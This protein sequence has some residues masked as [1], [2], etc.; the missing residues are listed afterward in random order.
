MSQGKSSVITASSAPDTDQAHHC[1]HC[2]DP[3]ATTEIV[4]EDKHFCCQGCKLVYEM[5]NEHE[6]CTYYDLEANPG[7]SLK[8]RR[9][10]GAF[11]YLDHAEIEASLL[12]FKD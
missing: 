10:E 9:D 2:G 1:Y 8:S 6:L 11:A 7:I 4:V 3:C 5:L 12:S